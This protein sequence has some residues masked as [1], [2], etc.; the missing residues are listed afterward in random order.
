[1]LAKVHRDASTQAITKLENMHIAFFPKMA[2]FLTDLELDDKPDIPRPG[3]IVI[4]YTPPKTASGEPAEEERAD[5]QIRI[6]LRPETDGLETVEL[7]M[8]TSP[9]TAYNMGTTLN[10][11]FS[12]R[13]GHEVLLAYV[14]TNSRAVLGSVNPSTTTASQNSATTISS[15][16]STLR[17]IIPGSVAEPTHADRI[18][19]QDCAQFLVVTSES[20]DDVSRRLPEGTEMDITK[21]RPN[22]VVKGAGKAWEEDYWGE[23]MV[24]DV[25]EK[26]I[27]LTANCVRCA[28]IN[29]DYTTGAPGTDESGTV[30]KKL[31][32]DRRVDK[33]KKYS[34]CFGRYG[35]CRVADV[36]K[37]IGVGEKVVV[38][39]VNEE[40]D[41]FGKLSIL[42]L[43]LVVWDVVAD[44]GV[45]SLAGVVGFG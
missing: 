41:T 16:F 17:S 4:T 34:P 35:F 39:R 10:S 33:G 30:L 1:M 18:A 27:T 38:S 15:V 28:S 44:D 24:G 3:N 40:R 36:G 31:Q 32:S 12:A 26:V 23:V 43:V 7:N 9:T 11:W 2:L 29:V 14:G 45:C 20:L 19:F 42:G 6:P 13:F 37:R 5:N 21:F 22:V 25:D 8:H